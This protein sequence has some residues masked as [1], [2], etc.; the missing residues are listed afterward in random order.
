MTDPQRT[1]DPVGL[2]RTLPAGAAIIYRHF[3]AS[4]RLDL[5]QT[6]RK[7]SRE[8]GLQFLIGADA[9]LAEQV[10]ADGVHL[11]ERTLER[12]LDLRL[13]HP[14]WLI[15]G[16]AHNERAV[17]KCAD[18][19]LDA[20]L[21]SPVFASTSPSAGTP[22]GVK[23]LKRLA[24]TYKVALMALGGVN[25]RTAPALPGTGAAGLAGVSGFSEGEL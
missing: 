4:N 2:A 13:R 20:A 9:K 7:A 24:G 25:V 1:S 18:L 10:G 19:N 21:L 22:L 23:A 17:A 6:L 3:G 15:T 11:P 12:V 5:A 14:A 8:C 16:A